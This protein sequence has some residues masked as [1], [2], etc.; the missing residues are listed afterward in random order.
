MGV[1]GALL[2]EWKLIWRRISKRVES[3]SQ[4]GRKGWSLED[5]IMF[6]DATSDWPFQEFKNVSGTVKVQRKGEETGQ[7]QKPSCLRNPKSMWTLE[8]SCGWFGFA[9]GPNFGESRCQ[10]TEVSVS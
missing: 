7:R 3:L 5:L 2:K 1:T 6:L 4:D 9:D 10:G 8:E